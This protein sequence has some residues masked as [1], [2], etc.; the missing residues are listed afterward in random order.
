[1]SFYDPN[2]GITTASGLAFTP[3]TAEG[4]EAAPE[5]VRGL[6]GEKGAAKL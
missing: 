3:I 2:V 4:Q 5:S 1:M 6:I